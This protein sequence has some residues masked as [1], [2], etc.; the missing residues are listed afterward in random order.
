MKRWSL[1]TH[2][3]CFRRHGC[4][5]RCSWRWS[6]RSSLWIERW[7][8]GARWAPFRALTRFVWV[9]PIG[10]WLPVRTL[11][12]FVWVPLL[13]GRKWLWSVPGPGW[14]LST[15]GPLL[16]FIFRCSSASWL[17]RS[18]LLWP[19]TS[20]VIFHGNSW[21]AALSKQFFNTFGV[22]AVLIFFKFFRYPV[23]A[24]ASD[25]RGFS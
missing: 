20:R 3:R 9:T 24:H 14:R 6:T 16:V 8:P 19:S 11:T 25:S 12:R 23:V 21:K 17:P 4:P 2:R 22:R 1:V 13:S 15:K 10:W 5:W 18:C 7:L